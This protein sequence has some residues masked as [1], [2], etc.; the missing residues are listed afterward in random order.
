MTVPPPTTTP[1]TLT[2]PNIPKTNWIQDAEAIAK[3]DITRL[4]GKLKR[5]CGSLTGT[6]ALA[7]TA[8]FVSCVALVRACH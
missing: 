2:P 3:A 8:L 4:E 6:L 1:P 5:V 7:L